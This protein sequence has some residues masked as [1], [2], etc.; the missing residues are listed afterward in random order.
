MIVE[1]KDEEN[2]SYLCLQRSREL[3]KIGKRLHAGCADDVSFELTWRADVAAGICHHRRLMR[4]R[5]VIG[6]DLGR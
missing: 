3:A 2:L 5:E 6:Y 4:W 1:K